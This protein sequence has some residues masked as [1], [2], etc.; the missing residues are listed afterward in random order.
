MDTLPKI[1]ICVGYRLDDK[2][3]DNIPSATSE[4]AR[5]QPVYETLD[6]WNVSTE[7][8]RSWDELSINAQQYVRFIE[9]YLSIP[10]ENLIILISIKF[11]FIC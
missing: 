11:V 6:G 9:E 1:K 8:V 4:F 5:I 10:G 3:L 2:D 7:N